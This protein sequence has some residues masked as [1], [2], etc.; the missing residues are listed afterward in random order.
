L[1]CS[2]L[3]AFTVS[4]TVKTWTSG[5]TLTAT[6]LNTTV[7]SLKTA[8]ESATQL[9]WS[10]GNATS[11]TGYSAFVGNGGTSATETIWQFPM[12][13][14]GIVKSS[15]VI[16][17]TNSCTVTGTLTL[18]KNGVDTGLVLSM[19]ASSL[20]AQTSSVTVSYAA[21][22]VLTWKLVC[23]SGTISSQVAF[24]F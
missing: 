9:G 2:A 18:R 22:D 11:G 6:D 8:V 20:A 5:E 10:S 4:G 21:G 16:P 14:D 13:R 12:P 19:P 3:F 15:R 24:E 7:Q 17:N 1:F 23:T